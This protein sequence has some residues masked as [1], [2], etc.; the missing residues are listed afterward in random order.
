[1]QLCTVSWKKNPPFKILCSI[2]K[3]ILQIPKCSSVPMFPE[4]KKKNLEES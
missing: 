3:Y 4:M 2:Y 1:M